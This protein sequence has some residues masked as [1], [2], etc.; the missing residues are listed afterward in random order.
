MWRKLSI[1]NWNEYAIELD[2][3]LGL[4]NQ[5]MRALGNRARK[6]PRRVVFA[7]ADNPKILKAAQIVFDEG[8]AFPILLG[9]EKKIRSIADTACN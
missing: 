3:R 9:N 8:G 5:L 1:T 6:D 4:D 7:E 2:K